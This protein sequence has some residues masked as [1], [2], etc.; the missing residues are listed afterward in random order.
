MENTEEIIKVGDTLFA[1]SRHHGTYPVTIER[2]TP[3]TFVVG[4]SKLRKPFKS[5][6]TAIG[7]S[8]FG[9]TFYYLPTDELKKSYERQQLLKYFR[10]IKFYDFN[11]FQLLSIK[12]LIKSF[13]S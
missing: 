3:T 2:E 5:G 11:T 8:G 13:T 1:Q 7:T 6:C 10:D 9:N 12:T 4:S